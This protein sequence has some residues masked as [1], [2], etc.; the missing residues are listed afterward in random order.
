MTEERQS[1]TLMNLHDR[2]L[3]WR[4]NDRQRTHGSPVPSMREG[5]KVVVEVEVAIVGED[6]DKV[7]V[8]HDKLPVGQSEADM[9]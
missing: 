1:R 2:R 8:V 9:M 7:V 6:D 5:P 3:P 4:D